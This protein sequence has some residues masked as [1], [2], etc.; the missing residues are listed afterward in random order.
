VKRLLPLGSTNAQRAL[1]SAIAV[2]AAGREHIVSTRLANGMQ[3][4]VWPDRNVPNVALYNWVRVGSRNESPGRTGL[5]HFFEHMMFNGTARH[6]PGEFDLI[7]ESHGGSSNAFTTDDVTVYQDWFPSRA[8]EPVLELEADR[9]AHLRFAPEVIERERSVVYSERRLRVDDSNAGFLAERV[10]ATAFVAHPYRF[11]TIG[12]P[13]DIKS[14]RLA[15]LQEFFRTYYA[16]NNQTLVLAGDVAPE[17]VL[18]LAHR[19]LEPIP[20][21]E[22][23][24]P[25]IVR[26]PEQTAERRFTVRRK[27]QSPLVQYAFKAPAASDPRAPAVNL[28]MAALVEG[29]ASRLHSLLVEQRK[30]AVEIGGDWHEGFDPSLFWLYATLPEGGDSKAFQ[31]E[32]DAE[33]ARVVAGGIAEG[34]LRRAKNLIAASF[35]KQR[36]TIDGKAH[37]LGEYALFH[38]DWRC[39]FDAPARYEAVTLAQVHAVARAILDPRHRTAGVL[40]PRSSPAR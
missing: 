10:Q 25:I 23:P 29:A 3:I 22:P 20:P 19:L 34:E 32:L 15:D 6:A 31:R 37:L 16:P 21:Q 24:A 26:E 8:L 17:H 4:I 39:M 30:L 9:I 14:W 40:R 38:G 11:P 2:S 1:P 27:G 18:A 33:L 28:L 35:W 7:M 12:W 13:A 5:A 36:A